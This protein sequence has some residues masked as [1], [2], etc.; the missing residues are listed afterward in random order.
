MGE[1]DKR[2]LLPDTPLACGLIAAWVSALLLLPQVAQSGIWDPFELER[3]ELARRIAVQLFGAADLAVEGALNSMPTLSDL[4][5][6]EL[7]FT[8]MAAGFA[9]FGLSDWAGRLPLA[10]WAWCGV[11]CLYAFVARYKSPRAG[12]YAACALATMPAYFIHARTMLGDAVTMAAFT[13]AFCGFVAPLFET[14]IRVRVAWIALGVLG[15]LCGYMSRGAWL[16]VAAPVGAAGMTWLALVGATKKAPS[17]FGAACLLIAAVALFVGSDLRPGDVQRAVGFAVQQTAPLESTFDL[18][19]RDIGHA[20][21][22]WS[23]LVPFAVGRLFSAD[24]DELHTAL[25]LGAACAYG[26]H[27]YVAPMSGTMPFVAPAV[28]A[29]IIGVAL[30]ELSDRAAFVGVGSAVVALLLWRDMQS[31]PLKAL[32]AFGIPEGELPHKLQLPD[33]SALTLACAV[34]ALGMC[35]SWLAPTT[36]DGSVAKWLRTRIEL[37]ERSAAELSRTW[38][39][40]LMFGFLVVEAMLVGLGAM[41]FIG[42]WFGWASVRE[43]PA[44]W[45]RVGTNL[46]WS[47]PLALLLT[48]LLF[49]GARA[50]FA[51]GLAR[52]RLPRGSGAVLSALIAGGLLCFSFYPALAAQLSPKE[53]FASYVRHHGPGEPLGVLGLSARVGR[54]YSSE[55]IKPL[56][57]ARSAL[58]WLNMGAAQQPPQRRWLVFRRNELA[59]LNAL[60][61]QTKK[62]NLPVVDDPDGEILLA[63]NRL[64]G[65]NL[66]PLSAIVLSAPP[67][68]QRRLNIRFEDKID[69]FGWDVVDDRGKL[70]SSVTP[71][72][73]YQL[74][75]YL[76][77]RAAIHRNYKAF[78][79]IDGF[80]RRHN[81]DHEVLGGDYRMSYWRPGDVLVDVYDLVLEPNFTPGDY[82]IYFGFYIGK[83]R[84]E[85]T[86][87]KH[88]DNRAA[89]G[90]LSVH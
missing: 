86:V 79:H 38:N 87:G 81:G 70:A 12:L 10:L 19:V 62:D 55:E 45:A 59:E 28:L 33:S 16:G 27:A 51:Y 31:I 11:M 9:A 35:F 40:N 85:V 75:F 52:M 56:A 36:I 88:H 43:I 25:L 53:M 21:F 50:L 1:G 18:T 46:W 65:P 82:A 77:A 72:R 78:I 44:A 34:F 8:S 48:P 6:G 68:V 2:T 23:A 83:E 60:Y 29:A 26:A 13:F 42:R 66:N 64:D 4:K 73:F 84:M 7:P 69:V 80:R 76:R 41:L 39:G 74:R 71:G 17:L 15:A 90:M 89:G 32:S 37:Y 67:E 3:A 49:D 5:S 54:Y 30:D 24:D 14:S 61:R 20:L 63:S 58:S 47:V 57:S 22:P